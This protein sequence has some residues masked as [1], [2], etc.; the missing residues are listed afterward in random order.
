MKGFILGCACTLLY[1]NS[2]HNRKCLQKLIQDVYVCERVE[3]IASQR[4][5]SQ[6]S[7]FGLTWEQ[8]A[9]TAKQCAQMKNVAFDDYNNNVWYKKLFMVIDYD[10]SVTVH[11]I[12]YIYSKI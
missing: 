4:N 10:D 6:R 3:R 9:Q 7:D 2:V 8:I 5:Q 1:T 12:K 11:G